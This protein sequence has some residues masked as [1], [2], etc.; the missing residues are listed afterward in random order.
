[1]MASII[2]GIVSAGSTVAL[3]IFTAVYVRHTSRQA[4]AAERSAESAGRAALAAERAMRAPPLNPLRGFPL[5]GSTTTPK[6]AVS[7]KIRG[8]PVNKRFR[9][10]AERNG[11]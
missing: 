6:P 11:V 2:A 8:G 3:A 4:A 10:N 5:H 7:S 9:C 1:M